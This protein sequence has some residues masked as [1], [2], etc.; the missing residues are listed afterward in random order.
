MK[1]ERLPEEFMARYRARPDAF[2]RTFFM[3]VPIDKLTNEEL[4][5]VVVYM[6]DEAD[7]RNKERLARPR[8]PYHP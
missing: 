8:V 4:M 6:A 7:R 2:S 1:E 3:C 5:S